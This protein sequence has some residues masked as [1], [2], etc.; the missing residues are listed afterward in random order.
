MCSYYKDVK[1]VPL[2]AWKCRYIVTETMLEAFD[3]KENQVSFLNWQVP[4]P[5]LVAF[6]NNKGA[7]FKVVFKL[8]KI[9]PEKI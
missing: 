8:I 9:A 3:M 2:D 5:Y 4:N 6:Y 1:H 7:F